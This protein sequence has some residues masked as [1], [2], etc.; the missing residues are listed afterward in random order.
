[1]QGYLRD[2]ASLADTADTDALNAPFLTAIYDALAS[3]EQ[4]L[5]RQIRSVFLINRV[6]RLN[7]LLLW[8]F[9]FWQTPMCAPYAN[10]V[11]VCHKYITCRQ[12]DSGV[13]LIWSSPCPPVC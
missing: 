4:V 13:V 12:D 9:C 11:A 7:A 5:Q 3:P 2:P 10:M 1:M 8:G 6:N